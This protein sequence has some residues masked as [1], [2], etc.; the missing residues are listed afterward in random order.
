M[1]AWNVAGESGHAILY[2][3]VFL[4][5]DHKSFAVA[6]DELVFH[7]IANVE[8]LRNHGHCPSELEWLP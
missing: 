2:V 8:V 3:F 7:N 1:L 4:C 6:T 5:D